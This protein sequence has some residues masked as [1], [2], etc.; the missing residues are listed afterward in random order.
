MTGSELRAQIIQQQQVVSGIEQNISAS[1]D[2]PSNQDL[3]QLAEKA[4]GL[5]QGAY[6][7]SFDNLSALTQAQVSAY[8]TAN[9]TYKALA[10]TYA[11]FGLSSVPSFADAVYQSAQELP[12]TLHNAG[13]A[14][15]TAAGDVV[16]GATNFALETIKNTLKGFFAGFGWFG[17]LL[18]ALA[19]IAAV[20][21]FF[22][23]TFAAVRGL[24]KA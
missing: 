3:Y 21:Y 15:G 4:R 12:Q 10:S 6:D 18:V 20:F 24:V 22:P 8:N 5:L 17:W 1:D 19:A 23:G 2:T 13:V 14:V 9:A 16:G 7:I 11:E